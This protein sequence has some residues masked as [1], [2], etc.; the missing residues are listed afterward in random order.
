MKIAVAMS[1]GLDSSMA[2]VL[3][4][5]AGY[6]VT[7]ITAELSTRLVERHF[8]R[9]GA[10]P[11]ADSAR[12]VA[13]SLGIPFH[14]LDLQDEFS[15]R[16][17]EPFCE[18][19][20]R[21]RT[22]NPCIRCNAMIKFDLLL[23]RARDLG[24]EKIA[25][26]HYA[27]INR[28]GSGRY[29]I[30]RGGETVKDQSYFLFMLSQ[31]SMKDIIFPLGSFT[32]D[33]VREMARARGL[34]VAERPESQEICFIPDNRY[35]DFIEKTPGAAPGP[36]DITDAAGA[37]IGR[38]RGIHR[39][40][41]GQRRGLGIASPRPLYV[42][43]IDAPSNRII[44]G[45][46]EELDA[47]ALVAEDINYMKETELDGLRVLVKT[48]STQPPVE[49]RLSV[50]GEYVTVSFP[51]PQTGISPGQAVVFYNGSMEVL[52][53]GIIER[54]IRRDEGKEEVHNV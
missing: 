29:Y 37:V 30:A 41:I 20:L 5:E 19:Y 31:D 16:I 13:E 15:T 10:P 11:G 6:E 27:T 3:L 32:K 51:G 14:V 25:T 4:T 45:F 22:P 1:G 17:V 2:A 49:A 38:H 33:M 24:C 21:G 23:R 7:G 53:G 12:S 8:A 35:A 50:D 39:Y 9:P 18:E 40:T 54:A 46:R 44:A 28:S 26:G 43:G 36:G 42:T 47:D 34:T 48:R 52:A